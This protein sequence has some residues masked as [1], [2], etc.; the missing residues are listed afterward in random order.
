[1]KEDEI[2]TTLVIEPAHETVI[3][4]ESIEENTQEYKQVAQHESIQEKPVQLETKRVEHIEQKQEVYYQKPVEQS[5][6]HESKPTLNLY[7]KNP[8][9]V[10][11]NDLDIP[12]F[13]RKQAKERINAE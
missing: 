10:D 3:K 5:Y 9:Q 13:M 6:Q 12:A 11:I 4:L 1:M 8:T 2:N 7:E